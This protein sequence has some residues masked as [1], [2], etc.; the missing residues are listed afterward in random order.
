MALHLGEKSILK[1]AMDAVPIESI[2]LVVKSIDF[3][4]VRNFLRFIAED[5]VRP[6]QPL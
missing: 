6:T 1:K 2:D 3:H 4:M 5:L